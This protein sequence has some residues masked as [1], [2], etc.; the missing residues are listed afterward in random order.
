MDREAKP[1]R[2]RVVSRSISPSH[3]PPPRRRI[4]SRSISPSHFPP[5]GS[6]HTKTPPS[7]TRLPN[8]GSVLYTHELGPSKRKHS[9][10]KSSTTGQFVSPSSVRTGPRLDLDRFEHLE[11][12]CSDNETS[13]DATPNMSDTLVSRQPP[14]L[15]STLINT[16]QDRTSRAVNR[17]LSYREDETEDCSEDGGEYLDEDDEDY[18]D[19]I[20]LTPYLQQMTPLSKIKRAVPSHQYN[21]YSPPA[22]RSTQQPQNAITLPNPPSTSSQ[23][24]T[25]SDSSFTLLTFRNTD[26]TESPGDGDLDDEYQLLNDDISDDHYDG[27]WL[28]NLDDIPLEEIDSDDPEDEHQNNRDANNDEDHSSDSNRSGDDASNDD[29]SSDDS[30]TDPP[31]P[32][33]G[34]GDGGDDGSSD[35]SDSD[36]LPPGGGGGGH[37]DHPDAPPIDIYIELVPY[38]AR[39]VQGNHLLEMRGI[40]LST[41]RSHVKFMVY[42]VRTTFPGDEEKRRRGQTLTTQLMKLFDSDTKHKPV[43][44]I[45]PPYLSFLYTNRQ[46]LNLQAYRH[47]PWF[48]LLDQ[49]PRMVPEGML[50]TR[51]SVAFIFMAEHNYALQFPPGTLRPPFYV[52]IRCLTGTR[53]PKSTIFNRR[54][55]ARRNPLSVE[56]LQLRLL[57]DEQKQYLEELVRNGHH[58]YQQLLDAFNR[59]Y[60]LQ[61]SLPTFKRIIKHN[62]GQRRRP[63]LLIKDRK[64]DSEEMACVRRHYYGECRHAIMNRHIIC[65]ADETWFIITIVSQL[66]ILLVFN[67][68]R[69]PD[70][71]APVRFTNVNQRMAV[72]AMIA[73]RLGYTR[74]DARPIQAV[75]LDARLQELIVRLNSNLTF[76]VGTNFLANRNPLLIRYAHPV[77]S[78]SHVQLMLLITRF[79]DYCKQI[80]FMLGPVTWHHIVWFADDIARSITRYAGLETTWAGYLLYFLLDV[81]ALTPSTVN[82][83]R[84]G[85]N[86][87]FYRLLVALSRYLK[88]IPV[89]IP[90]TG[91]LRE[92]LNL[93]VP[94][95]VW[96]GQPYTS[97]SMGIRL[98][99]SPTTSSLPILLWNYASPH[100]RELA[101]Q[102]PITH[103]L[104]QLSNNPGLEQQRA[105]FNSVLENLRPMNINGNMQNDPP[106]EPNNEDANSQPAQPNAADEPHAH[107]PPVEPIGEDADPQ[108]DAPP[109]LR[110]QPN[111]NAR[112]AVPPQLPPQPDPQAPVNMGYD[113]LFFFDGAAL[114]LDG[115]G[116]NN[117]DPAAL[118]HFRQYLAGRESQELNYP[119][120]IPRY[121]PYDPALEQQPAFSHDLEEDS[122]ISMLTIFANLYRCSFR[123][124][125]ITLPRNIHESFPSRFS[126]FCARREIQIIPPNGTRNI[127][128]LPVL[129]TKNDPGQQTCQVWFPTPYGE[130]QDI[131]RLVDPEHPG[132]FFTKVG[133]LLS[134]WLDMIVSR[135]HV[136]NNFHNPIHTRRIQNINILDRTT[137]RD[138]QPFPELPEH[139]RPLPDIRSIPSWSKILNVATPT[140]QIFIGC[141]RDEAAIIPLLEGDEL[142]EQGGN[143]NARPRNPQPVADDNDD[144]EESSDHEEQAPAAQPRNNRRRAPVQNNRQPDPGLGIHRVVRDHQLVGDH[145]RLSGRIS[146]DDIDG[147]PDG[148]EGDW[149]AARAAIDAIQGTL[150]GVLHQAMRHFQGDFPEDY[151]NAYVSLSKGLTC[152]TPTPTGS[153]QRIDMR[154]D[155]G[156]RRDPRAQHDSVSFHQWVRLTIIML[157]QRAILHNQPSILYIIDRA[158]YHRKLRINIPGRAGYT[159]HEQLATGGAYQRVHLI[160][161][162]LDH[163]VSRG[164]VTRHSDRPLANIKGQHQLAF[165]MHG[166]EVNLDGRNLDAAPAYRGVN[167]PADDDLV[168]DYHLVPDHHR[169][170]IEDASEGDGADDVAEDN[171][172]PNNQADDRAPFHLFERDEVLRIPDVDDPGPEIEEVEFNQP[173]TRVELTGL[174]AAQLRNLYRWLIYAKQIPKP[175]EIKHVISRTIQE[176]RELTNH[177]IIAGLNVRVLFTPPTHFE[178]NGIELLFGTAKK[179]FQLDTTQFIQF[180]DDLLPDIYQSLTFLDTLLITYEQSANYVTKGIIEAEKSIVN[181]MRCGRLFPEQNFNPMTGSNTKEYIKWRHVRQEMRQIA[182]MPGTEFN[183]EGVARVLQMYNNADFVAFDQV[184]NFNH[185]QHFLNNYRIPT[186][187]LTTFIASPPPPP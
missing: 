10:I 106:A 185:N 27:E 177:P 12:P 104:E 88:Y 22:L 26:S 164:W 62:G 182:Q 145:E 128:S 144:G 170:V 169:I 147:V 45:A 122:A 174:S 168:D 41:H 87:Q 153:A 167:N 90:I 151:I 179:N 94:N 24:D 187:Y 28:P 32:G 166:I 51:M 146:L 56:P 16:K 127:T 35:D 138:L 141:V 100:V 93:P 176:L 75:P 78:E 109:Q 101:Q 68:R 160:D 116:D 52:Y 77:G 19:P 43:I 129:M 17:R 7:I 5:P 83:S 180:G 44:H 39:Y 120:E 110:R 33:G 81:G 175:L 95:R 130:T 57:S 1:T 92:L 125:I 30:D 64:F 6:R 63:K 136:I 113:R 171:N 49:I 86:V 13:D 18:N 133:D 107:E 134:S 143:A 140:W 21:K 25:D 74:G 142:F 183:E 105:I 23:S 46:P 89:Q 154:D 55:D 85:F 96:R 36:P 186:E 11:Q 71:P 42:V 103:F 65:K 161:F 112:P 69:V 9:Y 123:L 3:S 165:T 29:S 54:R 131:D 184:P 115:G 156:V 53:I 102:H 158:S 80:T 155:P 8:P 15:R 132:P 47:L 139:M 84:V 98:D 173:S 148:F 73:T 76:M 150:T 20:D 48:H 159:R 178:F 111:R 66:I 61:Y 70:D 2:R 162:L 124:I 149:D 37:G 59:D 60:N 14:P 126:E 91:R 58:T 38:N 119:T 157:A 152:L 50:C 137:L 121:C 108:P 31:P 118:G 117:D 135:H 172:N 79:L 72:L 181:D 99:P 34:G 82:L 40:R 4:V 163:R 114:A 97:T 67:G